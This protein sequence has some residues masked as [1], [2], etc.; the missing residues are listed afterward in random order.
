[1]KTRINVGQADDKPIPVDVIASSIVA[2]AD[3]V[4]KLNASKLTQRALVLLITDAC[5]PINQ[6][7]PRVRITQ[8]QVKAVL[9]GMSSLEAQFIKKP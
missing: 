1:M 9:A 8:S 4:K 7:H 5:P 2:I 6:G 3:G